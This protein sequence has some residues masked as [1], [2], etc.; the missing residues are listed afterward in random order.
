MIRFGRKRGSVEDTS[1]GTLHSRRVV[2]RVLGWRDG[3]DE[4]AAWAV[5]EL[6]AHWGAVFDYLLVS[7][8]VFCWVG[9]DERIWWMERRHGIWKCR[10]FVL[11]E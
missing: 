6:L 3:P 9:L 1:C 5:A 11:C 2:R 4:G 10:L 7:M 8:F